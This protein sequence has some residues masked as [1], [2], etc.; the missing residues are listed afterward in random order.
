LVKKIASAHLA[1]SGGM[2]Q[3][4]MVIIGISHNTMSYAVIPAQAGIQSIKYSPQRG[5]KSIKA[6]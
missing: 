4:Q 6:F 5:D 3:S 2:H 1:L